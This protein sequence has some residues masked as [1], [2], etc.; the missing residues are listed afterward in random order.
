MDRSHGHNC[1]RDRLSVDIGLVGEC[2]KVR[3]EKA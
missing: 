2:I 3:R 1:D